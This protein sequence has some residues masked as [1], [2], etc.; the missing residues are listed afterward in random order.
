MLPNTCNEPVTLITSSDEF[1]NLVEPDWYTIEELINSVWNSSAVTFPVTV[2]SQV[3]VLS[4][5]VNAL[6]NV[7][8]DELNA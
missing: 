3:M 1:P 8:Y 2:K 7:E 5:E 4:P 6:A